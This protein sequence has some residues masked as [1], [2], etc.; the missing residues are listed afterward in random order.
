MGRHKAIW[1]ELEMLACLS[2]PSGL[3]VQD[4]RTYMALSS[5]SLESHNAQEFADVGKAMSLCRVLGLPEGSDGHDARRRLTE[6]LQRLERRGLVELKVPA[7]DWEVTVAEMA[8]AEQRRYRGTANPR[9]N[10]IRLLRMNGDPHSRRTPRPGSGYE[11]AKYVWLRQACVEEIIQLPDPELVLLL[12]LF[13]GVRLNAFGGVDQDMVSHSGGVPS[14]GSTVTGLYEA[15]RKNN[16][17][18]YG[19]WRGTVW[20][21]EVVLRTLIA[22]GFFTWLDLKMFSVPKFGNAVLLAYPWLDKTFPARERK[23]TEVL[24]PTKGL[25]LGKNAVSF[26]NSLARGEITEG[27]LH[28]ATIDSLKEMVNSHDVEYESTSGD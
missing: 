3:R 2:T 16:P 8:Q 10:I 14:L 24:V 11:T 22:K 26:I 7:T 25:L 20:R 15:A 12:F 17:D 28:K 5:R 18:G 13:S 6:P 19:R 1:L 27:E 4:L 9:E 23:M 21:P